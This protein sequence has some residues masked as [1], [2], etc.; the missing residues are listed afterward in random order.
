MEVDVCSSRIAF[1]CALRSLISHT[2]SHI[3]KV[4]RPP[5]TSHSLLCPISSH[6]MESLSRI[7]SVLE[8][9]RDL[10]LEAAQ[11]ASAAGRTGR[12]VGKQLSAKETRKLLNSRMDR[13]VL[14]GLQRVITVGLG[15][16]CPAPPLTTHR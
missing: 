16:R 2:V 15:R 10:T 1:Q 13:E 7:S 11:S 12:R 3:E 9:A 6:K 8:T 5:A 4:N 14:D